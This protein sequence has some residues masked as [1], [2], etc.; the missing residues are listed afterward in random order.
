MTDTL[1]A[2][3]ARI[4]YD[5]W[6]GSIGP[7]HPQAWSGEVRAIVDDEYMVVR[8]WLRTKQ[9]WEYEVHWRWWWDE[10]HF[11]PGPLRTHVAL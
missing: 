7:R 6:E 5:P 3:G 10:G 8:R 4:H 1:P 2:I 9:R 11:K